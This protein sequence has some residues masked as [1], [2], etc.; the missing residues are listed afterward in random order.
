MRLTTSLLVCLAASVAS[1]DASDDD[2]INTIV[3][4]LIAG[5]R[6]VCRDQTTWRV[7]NADGTEAASGQLPDS[8]PLLSPGTNPAKLDFQEQAAPSFRVV[9]K[10][11]KVYP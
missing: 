3:K 11:V 6:L 7:F 1:L 5:Q 4:R 9:V 10:I 8:F 2:T